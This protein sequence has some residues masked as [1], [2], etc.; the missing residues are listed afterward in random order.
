M[1]RSRKTTRQDTLNYI[2]M[3]GI[4]IIFLF[5]DSISDTLEYGTRIESLG[6]TAFILT[7]GVFGI[8]VFIFNSIQMIIQYSRYVGMRKELAIIKRSTKNKETKDTKEIT[9]ENK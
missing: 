3:V 2:V 1:F 7:L 9:K 6:M 4:A 8:E 5:S